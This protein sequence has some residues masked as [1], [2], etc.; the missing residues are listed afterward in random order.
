MN[1]QKVANI[2][3][4]LT[5]KEA[6]QTQIDAAIDQTIE[7]GFVVAFI[8]KRSIMSGR[9]ILHAEWARARKSERLF[10]AWLD[11]PGT[12][13]CIPKV[14][15]SNN[16]NNHVTIRRGPDGSPGLWFNKSDADDLLVRL[17]WVIHMQSRLVTGKD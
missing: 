15:A 8:S 16:S 13:E 2:S 5:G 4:Y 10:C 9:N 11:P 17:I 6:W 1:L 14:I 7:N 3:G 12:M